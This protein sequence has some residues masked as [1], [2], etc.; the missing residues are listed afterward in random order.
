MASREDGDHSARGELPLPLM[1]SMFSKASGAG[2]R[3]ARAR[4]LC[5]RSTVTAIDALNV[6]YASVLIE[7]KQG[8]DYS[9]RDELLLALML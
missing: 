5:Q 2:R 1:L 3:Q 6:Q 9:A 8:P 7:R 4:L